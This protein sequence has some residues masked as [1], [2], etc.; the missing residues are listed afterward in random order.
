MGDP[1]FINPFNQKLKS[2]GDEFWL[3]TG[4]NLNFA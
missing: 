3:Q 1:I 2:Q 4:K